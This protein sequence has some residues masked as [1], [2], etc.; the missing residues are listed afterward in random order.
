MQRHQTRGAGEAFF[1]QERGC[2]VVVVDGGVVVHG[3]VGYRVHRVKS[4]GKVLSNDDDD[5]CALLKILTI[6]FCS[7]FQIK[8]TKSEWGTM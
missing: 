3:G 1:L 6:C 4:K 5:C 8:K 7:L 2:V